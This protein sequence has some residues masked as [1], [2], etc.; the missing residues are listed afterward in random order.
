MVLGALR[1]QSGP[2]LRRPQCAVAQLL[3]I[4]DEL[5]E[6]AHRH[7][8]PVGFR[9]AGIAMDEGMPQREVGGR[10]VQNVGHGCLG[11]QLASLV[12]MAVSDQ[13]RKRTTRTA[14]SITP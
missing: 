9:V 1:P 10:G 4:C 14:R 6:V 8:D 11:S 12:A 3:A 7:P 2:A 13:S 5:D